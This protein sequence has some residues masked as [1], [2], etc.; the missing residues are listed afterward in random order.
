MDSQKLQLQLIFR[1][2]L[3][4][5]N[6]LIANGMSAEEMHALRRS[7]VEWILNRQLGKDVEGLDTRH[8]SPETTRT[9]LKDI[10]VLFAE[11]FP[12]ADF[13]DALLDEDWDMEIVKERLVPVHPWVRKAE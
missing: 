3:D 11:K 7:T 10:R 6:N 5:E 12:G 8:S 2:I 4:I 13:E 9:F 1:S